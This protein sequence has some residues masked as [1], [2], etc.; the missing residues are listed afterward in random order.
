M[1][2]QLFPSLPPELRLQIWYHALAPRRIKITRPPTYQQ[3][4]KDENYSM[5]Q[6]VPSIL[7]VNTEAR[8]FALKYYE[9]QTASNGMKFYFSPEIDGLEIV[10]R[11][12]NRRER[13]S[14]CKR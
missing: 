3:L 11:V 8:E 6:T 14:L 10:R 13:V 5:T 12:L 9:V 2:F 4:F 7:H 1:T